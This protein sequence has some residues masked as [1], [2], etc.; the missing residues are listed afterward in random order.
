MFNIK[1]IIEAYKEDFNVRNV[2]IE[3]IVSTSF[4][5]ELYG[6]DGELKKTITSIKDINE[7]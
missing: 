4:K 7:L 6:Y 2:D 1:K 3:Y 5:A